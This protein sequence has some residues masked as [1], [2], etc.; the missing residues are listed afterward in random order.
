MSNTTFSTGDALRYGWEMF[1]KHAGFVIG[2]LVISWL[3]ILVSYV[4]YFGALFTESGLLAFVTMLLYTA[5]SIVIG[6]G[7]LRIF[8]NL[9]DGK[10]VSFGQL[11]Q[12]WDRFWVYLGAVILSSIVI[13]FGFVLL[14]V[15]G[16]IWALKY[17]FV[18]YLAVDKK[19]GVMDTLRAAGEG[20]KGI[21]VDLL[22]F[23]IVIGL[24]NFVGVLALGIGMFVTIP[25]S[26]FAM[27]YVY[28][29]IYGNSDT[30]PAVEAEA[31]A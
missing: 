6:M 22:G 31:T 4:P 24:V 23:F 29:K 3:I 11:F 21:K 20:T 18:Q 1:K 8:L 19:A 2:L 28:R 10:E 9:H 25:M 7:M 26:S 13:M 15:P 17:S 27:A 12:V 30:A 5:V 14:V 16:I